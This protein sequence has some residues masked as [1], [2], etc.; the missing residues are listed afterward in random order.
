M[1]AQRTIP[2]D[3]SGDAGMCLCCTG[4]KKVCSAL[5]IGEGELLLAVSALIRNLT[6]LRYKTNASSR[7]TQRGLSLMVVNGIK[8]SSSSSVIKS[9]LM[10]SAPSLKT[11]LEM[12][13]CVPLL[14]DT[15]CVFRVNNRGRR[16]APQSYKVPMRFGQ[17]CWSIWDPFKNVINEKTSTTSVAFFLFIPKLFDTLLD[18]GFFQNECLLFQWKI[19]DGRKKHKFH[20]LFVIPSY[21]VYL[22]SLSPDIERESFRHSQNSEKGVLPWKRRAI[23]GRKL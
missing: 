6:N 2:E 16:I 11:S 5:I 1:T 12:Q 20:K 19:P 23:F 7:K 10:P 18:S 8:H 3:F 14:I 17:A 15:E 21:P 4:H 9:P 22:R 13:A